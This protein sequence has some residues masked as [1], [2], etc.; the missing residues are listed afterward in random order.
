MR[1]HPGGGNNG[2]KRPPPTTNKGAAA[3]AAAA[4][5]PPPS[6]PPLPR[7][8]DASL[9]LAERRWA[10]ASLPVVLLE[11]ALDASSSTRDV[12]DA[13]SWLERRA[14]PRLMPLS[15]GGA[16]AGAAAAAAAAPSP[17]LLAHAKLP[18]L[19]LCNALLR[20]LAK[21]GGADVG[22]T[23][24][25]DEDGGNGGGGGGKDGGGGGD[26]DDDGDAPSSSS[27]AQLA[28][29]VLVLLARLFPLHERSGV[30]PSG[31]PN[32]RH[33]PPP[34][35]AVP[36]GAVDSAGEPVD[37]ALYAAFWGLQRT[38]R[39]P[40][41]ELLLQ[42]AA[43]VAAGGGAASSALAQQQAA[44][45]NW[46]RFRA[47]V[48]SVL[49]AL[50]RRPVTVAAGGVPGAA[51]A[52]TVGGGAGAGASAAAGAGGTGAGSYLSSYRLFGL[53]LRDASFRRAFLVQTLIALQ[54]LREPLKPQ[55]GLAGGLSS[56]SAAAGGSGAPASR[57]ALAEAAALEARLYAALEATPSDGRRFAVAV[58]RTLERED[59]WARWKR[60]EAAAG[61]GAGGLPPPGPGGAPS[62][63]VA[64]A[65]AAA[66]A[67]SA[68]TC[69]DWTRPPLHPPLREQVEAA[70]GAASAGRAA[71]A[72]AERAAVAA[73][74]AAR[75]RA[76]RPDGEDDEDVDADAEA[77]VALAVQQQPGCGGGGPGRPA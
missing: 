18:C 6:R 59:A 44:A 43:P 49:D 11:D 51:A 40:G 56:S 26:N 9:A 1:F 32:D 23:G 37:A 58:R 15:A 48:A 28:A 60:P 5:A 68:A 3:A 30:N 20:R 55:E 16:G 34:V 74:S 27:P 22:G 54:A 17:P 75:L 64:A 65:A 4:A 50:E 41:R 72:A 14:A 53:Q 71:A 47:D 73:L 25:T 35:D 76:L 7:L 38:L 67:A 52:A 63:A 2:K 29:R 36:P 70:E 10:D 19:R 45:G 33:P 24:A 69:R 66:K 13:F 39:Q 12:A 57:A 8:L 61:A 42:P 21:G 46:R 77:E 62:S 31:A